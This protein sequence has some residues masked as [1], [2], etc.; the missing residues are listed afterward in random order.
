MTV[1]PS[2]AKSP[3]KA[4]PSSTAQ[5]V[6]WLALQLIVIALGAAR[7][8]LAARYPAPAEQL[9]PHLLLCTQVIVVSLLF[10]W[11]LN[12]VRA[13]VQALATALPFQLASAYLAGNSARE[14]LGALAFVDGFILVL[15]VW[16]PLLRSSFA[17]SLGVSL[18]SCLTLGGG[19]LRYLRVEYSGGTAE[20]LS[21]TWETV[22][23]LPSTLTA[24][25]GETPV[26][27]WG[28]LAVLLVAGIA[29]H[30]ISG[31]WQRA[32]GATREPSASSLP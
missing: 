2:A 8:P 13:A 25:A 1:I 9:A 26:G 17:Q 7:V 21:H 5:L 23:P 4:A 28:V 27:G 24:L 30:V 20:S 31:R 6:V 18:A 29:F 32:H 14:I 3:A 15:A 10:P 19:M 12:D 22:T 16:R 11:L